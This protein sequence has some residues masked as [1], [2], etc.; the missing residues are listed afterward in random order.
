MKKF[1]K[2]IDVPITIVDLKEVLGQG[3]CFIKAV[4][5]KQKNLLIILKFL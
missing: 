5:K 2:E 1:C 4:L 3:I